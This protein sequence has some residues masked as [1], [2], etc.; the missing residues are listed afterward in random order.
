[1]KAR[2][3]WKTKEEGGRKV[4]PLG[5]AEAGVH[6]YTTMMNFRGPPDATPSPDGDWS[7]VVEELEV[8]NEHE[9][10]AD[11]Y[12]LVKEAPAAELQPGRKFALYEGWKCVATGVL[13]EE[14]KRS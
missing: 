14:S 8:L 5:C 3:R 2:I 11:V 6:P 1:M 10:I 13:L 12:F 9:W 4:P 7:L